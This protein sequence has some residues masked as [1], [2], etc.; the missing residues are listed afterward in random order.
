M[1]RSMREDSS[2]L[3]LVFNASNMSRA[4]ECCPRNRVGND[5]IPIG[6]CYIADRHIYMA[7]GRVG[8]AGTGILNEAINMID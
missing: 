1:N 4:V 8:S 6:P 3:Q 2:L 5:A 7:G